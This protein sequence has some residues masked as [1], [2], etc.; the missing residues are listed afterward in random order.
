MEKQNYNNLLLKFEKYCQKHSAQFTNQENDYAKEVKNKIVE[1]KEIEETISELNEK[2]IAV[3]FDLHPDPATDTVSFFGFSIRMKRQDP[4]IPIQVDNITTAYF[5]DSRLG[6]SDMVQKMQ[7]KLE[8]D[9][10]IF[11]YT[12]ARV[13]TIV[14]SLLPGLS[15]FECE[16]VRNVRNHLLEHPERKDSGISPDTFSY[17]KNQGPVV[18]GMRINGETHWMDKGLVHNSN[19]FVRNLTQVLEKK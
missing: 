9:T 3:E 19:E 13:R 1:L 15:S 12:A 5:K 2:L 7:R 6:V 10:A 8:R 18:K 4:N 16:G 14:Q 17:S 11:Y